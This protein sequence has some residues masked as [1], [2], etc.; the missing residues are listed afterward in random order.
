M[1]L[2]KTIHSLIRIILLLIVIYALNGKMFLAIVDMRKNEAYAKCP[3]KLQ[4]H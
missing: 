1:V 4:F 2:S 3:K